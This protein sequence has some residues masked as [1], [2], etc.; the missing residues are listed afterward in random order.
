LRKVAGTEQRNGSAP[1]DL[2]PIGTPSPSETAQICADATEV[3]IAAKKA[4]AAERRNR[5]RAIL[6]PR[7]PRL[8]GWAQPLAVGIHLQLQAALGDAVESADLSDFLKW[9][10]RRSEY[11]AALARGT[12]RQ[13]L[14]GSDAGPAF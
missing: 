13:N 1:P 5:V 11:K 4:V 2:V 9:W 3:E 14:D 8:F 10:T 7:W 12:R 6:E